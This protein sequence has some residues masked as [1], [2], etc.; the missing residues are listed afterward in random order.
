MT[1]N[2]YR[3]R[4]SFGKWSSSTVVEVLEAPWL[5][6]DRRR[7]DNMASV[8]HIPSNEIF[9]IPAL[10]LVPVRNREV[11]NGQEEISSND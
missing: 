9:E 10:Y 11:N 7:T 2:K 6:D 3:I 5:T 8:H 1:P 4:K